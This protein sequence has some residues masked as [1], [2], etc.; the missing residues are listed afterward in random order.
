MPPI[1]HP[2]SRSPLPSPSHPLA[3]S[4][5][6]GRTGG[7]RWLLATP[8]LLA[9]VA[10]GLAAPAPATPAVL[11]ELFTSQGCSSCPP[12]DRV[13][14]I[15]GNDPQL[16][17]Q[18]VPLA[19]HVDYWN[20]IGWTDPF[21]SRDWS[22]RQ[23]NYVRPVGGEYAYTPQAIINGRL[24]CLGA[25]VDCIRKAVEAESAQPAGQVEMAVAAA[26]D[27]ALRVEVSAT[28][29]STGERSLDVMVALVESGLT[30]P[31]GRGENASKVLHND[32]VVRKLQRAFVLSGAPQRKVVE[33]PIG[34][35]WQ[36]ANMRVTVFLQEPKS[37]R[38]VGVAS[39]ALPG[40]PAR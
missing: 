6:R 29:P 24:Q 19:F 30:T 2:T 16:G 28:P 12:A 32:F 9:L 23:R 7:R 15:M 36:R 20:H 40:A 18:V 38:I 34:A 37:R 3:W 25:D 5:H 26:G 14:S 22:Q 27:R 13:L 33:L 8:V 39:A 10:A 11:V 35:D 4:P 31:V 17:Q 21:S 1:S